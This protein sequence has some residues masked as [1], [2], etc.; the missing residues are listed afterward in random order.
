MTISISCM[1]INNHYILGF[2]LLAVVGYKKTNV[3]THVNDNLRP[4]RMN[5]KGAF[6]AMI[7]YGQH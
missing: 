6:A 2:A 1:P 5:P 4:S 7:C 3:A